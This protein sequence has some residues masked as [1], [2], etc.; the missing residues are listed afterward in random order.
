MNTRLRLRFRAR[1]TRGT[2][3]CCVWM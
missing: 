2:T 3:V 1:T